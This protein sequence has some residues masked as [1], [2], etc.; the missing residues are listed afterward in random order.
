MSDMRI[1][2]ETAY[3]V[4]QIM[5][6]S[7][8]A[9][10]ERWMLEFAAV[11]VQ[12]TACQAMVAAEQ[13][14]RRYGPMKISVRSIWDEL[15]RTPLRTELEWSLY[16]AFPR[17]SARPIVVP[18]SHGEDLELFLAADVTGASRDELIA[19]VRWRTVGEPEFQTPDFEEFAGCVGERERAMFGKLYEANGLVQWNFSLPDYVPCYLDLDEP[20]DEDLGSGVLYHYDLNPL[21]PPKAVMGLLLGMV[22]EVT[23]LHLLGGLEGDE[24]EEEI[25]VRDLASDLELDL[26]A[27]LAARRL[28]QKVRP[29]LAAAQWFDSPSIPAPG[30]LRWALVFDAAGSVEGLLLGHR[31]GVND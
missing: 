17:P 19:P 21:V 10:V 15:C 2:R 25:D 23:A 20:E 5:G 27:W 29:G 9:A 31:Y 16:G 4:K 14:A 26:I 11:N 18:G 30:T 6:R 3:E 24:D 28:R 7:K 8:R 12:L 22:T 1:L 13:L